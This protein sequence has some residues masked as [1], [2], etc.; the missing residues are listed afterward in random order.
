MGLE[1][2]AGAPAVSG[3]EGLM[4]IDET[5]ARL[6]ESARFRLCPGEWKPIPE[7]QEMPEGGAP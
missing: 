1:E 5:T 2:R 7:G 3:H 6:G 4:R